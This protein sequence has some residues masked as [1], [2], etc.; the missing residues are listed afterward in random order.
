MEA[1]VRLLGPPAARVAGAWV[2]LRPGRADAVFAF[3]ARRGAPVRRA[4]VAALLW[5][6]SPAS[7]ASA[8]LRQALRTLS[9]SPLEGLLGR[10]H[11]R[12]WVKDRSDLATF[13]DALREARWGDAVAAYQGTFLDGFELGQADEFSAWLEDERAAIDGRFRQ[14]CVTLIEDAQRRGEHADGLDLA[15][16]VLRVDPLDETVVRHALRAAAALGDRT[17]VRRRFEAFRALLE[18]EMA[19]APEEATLALANAADALSLDDTALVLD[20]AAGEAGATSAR[21]AT[22]VPTIRTARRLIARDDVLATLRASLIDGD[23][24][25]VT[26]LAA[27]GMGKTTVAG[28]F[29]ERAADAF[30]GGVV[31]VPLEGVEDHRGVATAMA[32][33]ARLRIDGGV[34]IVP[35]LVAGL[36]PRASLLVLDA[37]E[38]HLE[39]VGLVD[40]LVRA[41]NARLRILVTSR[42]RLRHASERV[43]GLPPLAIAPRRAARPPGVSDD[44]PVETLSAAARLF[45][46]AMRRRPE[47]TTPEERAIAERV[48]TLLGG[49]PLALEL[50]GVWGSLMP[51]DT[52]HDELQRG[53][54]LLASDDVDRSARHRDVETMLHETWRRLDDADRRAFAR[55]SV[56]GGTIERNLAAAVAGSGWRGL[57]RLVDRAL[58]R[59]VGD[60]LEI[61]ALLG[62]FGRERAAELGLVDEA[63]DAALATLVERADAVMTLASGRYQPLAGDDLTHAVGAWRHAVERS[64]WSA[65]VPLV[66]PVLRGLVRESRYREVGGLVATATSA[67]EQASG[68]ARDVALARLLPWRRADDLA[69]HRALIDETIALAERYGDDVALAG[70]LEEKLAIDPSAEDGTLFDA[71]RAALERA[72]DLVQLAALLADRS[73]EMALRGHDDVS[74]RLAERS[75]DISRRIGDRHGEALAIDTLITVPL[76]HGDAETVRRGIAE[77]EALFADTRDSQRSII[78]LATEA[79]L[80]GVIEDQER[81]EAYAHAFIDANRAFVD[82][83]SGFEA[84]MLIGHALRRGDYEAVVRY[85]ERMLANTRASE[86][87]ATFSSL[88]RLCLVPAY[89]RLGR[90]AT[91]LEHVRAVSVLGRS[92]D[93]PRIAAIGLTTGAEVAFALGEAALGLDLLRMGWRHPAF[94]RARRNEARDLVLAAG[95]T[96]EALGP[97]PGDGVPFDDTVALLAALD[98]ALER[99][100]PL[101]RAREAVA[102]VGEA[103]AT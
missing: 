7:L 81:A 88:A 38:R 27:G 65:L 99:L 4:E 15:D 55:L 3:A 12:V 39:A 20:A 94:D 61:H 29:V 96:L 9:R 1:D 103:E 60:R 73:F 90:P 44:V 32:A 91:A 92:L 72:G 68:P 57:R 22:I 80:C 52:L 46:D 58:V 6:E 50:A 102:P 18:R 86:R 37:F 23:E 13:E 76:M 63:W 19:V 5:P 35:Q 87:P 89:T 17:G 45:F 26:L 28:A 33:A 51:L 14:A 16:R 54:E 24:R 77:A 49:T 40:A 97:G 2:P 30:A 31:Y 83:V 66:V 69:A 101:A 8:S 85:G 41:P 56:L 43:V 79:W 42:E 82:D 78:T 36:A 21:S 11:E 100:E 71:T 59:T 48:A 84:T 62:R 53:W 67:L 10:D 47:S 95:F 93:A 70:A 98:E 34:P 75:L 64:T 25:L 74:V